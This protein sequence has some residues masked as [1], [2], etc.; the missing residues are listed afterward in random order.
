[1]QLRRKFFGDYGLLGKYK[2]HPD[3]NQEDLFFGLLKECLEMG[4]VSQEMVDF[5]MAHNHVRHD[6]VEVVS[7]VRPLGDTLKAIP[8]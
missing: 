5:E 7:R 6:A 1:M 2:N 8:A 3:K 4:T